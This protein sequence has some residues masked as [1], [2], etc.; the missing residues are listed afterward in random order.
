MTRH[1]FPLAGLEPEP[2]AAQPSEVILAE[3]SI[4]KVL[5]AFPNANKKADS[6]ICSML[7]AWV[8]QG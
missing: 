1:G 6:L 7:I 3:R 5:M 8:Q 2:K 4:G